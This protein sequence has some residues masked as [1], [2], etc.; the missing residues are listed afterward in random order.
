VRGGEGGRD[1]EG[2]RGESEGISV[3]SYLGGSL[4]K[5]FGSIYKILCYVY[6]NEVWEEKKTW[7]QNKK[8]SQRCG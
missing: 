5:K 3:E 1:G 7:N 2:V 8:A 4:L 6:P